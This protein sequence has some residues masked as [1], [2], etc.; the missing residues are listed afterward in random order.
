MKKVGGTPRKRADSPSPPF[1]PA[2]YQPP[3][4]DLNNV[5]LPKA[6]PGRIRE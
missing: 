6:A 1:N 3:E 5:T 2:D 4:P